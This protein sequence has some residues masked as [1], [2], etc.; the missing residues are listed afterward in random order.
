MKSDEISNDWMNDIFNDDNLW[1]V[2]GFLRLPSIIAHEYWRLR[3]M[4]REKQPY[5]VYFQI[6]DLAE[7]ILKFEVLSVCAWAEAS[8]IQGF[9]KQVGCL[10]TTRG[11]SLGAWYELSRRIQAFFKEHDNALP[12]P[13]SIALDGIIREYGEGSSFVRK[14]ER[15]Q[16][17]LNW[18]NEKIGH[19]ALGFAEGDAFRQDIRTMIGYFK[20]LFETC[21]K[22]SIMNVADALAQ[23]KLWLNGIPLMG[24]ESARE[25][26]EAEGELRIHT[27]KCNIDF[28]LSPYIIYDAGKIYFFDN[29]KSPDRTQ[30]QCY[31]NGYRK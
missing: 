6:R 23:Q 20:S 22:N 13:F 9:Q 25:L 16:S 18:R 8:K 28:A 15:A 14:H 4:F 21:P 19:G 5:G 27:D 7:T 11:L 30:Q 3:D 26:T 1:Y 12:A 10:I 29:Q 24:Y 17:I 2:D 31:M